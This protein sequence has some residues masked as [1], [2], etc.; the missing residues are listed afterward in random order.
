MKFRYRL[1]MQSQLGQLFGVSSHE[2][3][4][5]LVDC[6]L[7]DQRTKKPTAEAHQ[8][9]YCDQAP[10]G[11]QSGYCWAWDAEQTVNL[12]VTAGHKLLTALPEELVLPPILNGPFTISTSCPSEVINRDGTL[13][14]R[15]VGPQNAM[16]VKSLLD[17]AYR[18]GVLSRVAKESSAEGAGSP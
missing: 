13:A 9:G 14:V 12:L 16:I 8:G 4:K 18:H 7:R 6:G 1:L 10:S 3:G 15:T 17:L 11:L 5:W 2:I